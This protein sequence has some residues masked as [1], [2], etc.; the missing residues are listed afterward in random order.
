MWDWQKGNILYIE[1]KLQH[2]KKV[3]KPEKWW[4]EISMSSSFQ[5]LTVY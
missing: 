1:K 5:L 2:L 3:N 4:A